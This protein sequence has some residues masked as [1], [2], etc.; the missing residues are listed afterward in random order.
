[1]ERYSPLHREKGIN[2]FG[3]CDLIDHKEEGLP[4]SKVG[5]LVVAARKLRQW[6]SIVGDAY[7]TRIG[8]YRL[9]RRKI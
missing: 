3:G 1:M 8:E 6:E 4:L 5:V 2:T 7:K 9:K